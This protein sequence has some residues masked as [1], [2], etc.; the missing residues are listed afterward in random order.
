MFHFFREASGL[1]MFSE[2]LT[3]IWNSMI[4]QWDTVD[5]GTTAVWTVTHVFSR[6]HVLILTSSVTVTEEV[7][8]H[9]R[10]HYVEIRLLLFSF[11]RYS[12]WG[13]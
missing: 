5:V 13:V 10:T 7:T 12:L 3:R 8:Q 9:K 1:C 4:V 11:P 2:N 6:I